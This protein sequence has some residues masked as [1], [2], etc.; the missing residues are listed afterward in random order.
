[1][2]SDFLAT[3]VLSSSLLLACGGSVPPPAAPLAPAPPPPPVASA[4]P[5]PVDT[6][7]PSAEPTP[8][9]K[10]KAEALKKLQEDRTKWQE[11]N[12]AEL[13]RWTPEMHAAAKAL[14]DKTYPNMRAA[15]QA[16]MAS[17]HRKPGN[18]DRDKYRHP[19][20]TLTFFGVKPMMSVLEVGPGDGWYTELIAPAV[21][22]KGKLV[23]TVNDPNGPEDQRGTFFGQRFKALLDK[24]PELFGNVQTVVVDGKAP[25]L[26]MDGTIDLVLVM[27]EIHGMVDGGT[28]DAWLGEIR[29]ALKPNGVL[30]IEEHRAKGD[31]DPAESA[32][33]GYVPEKWL[34]DHVEAAGFKLAGKSEVN[35]NPKDT[36][37]YPEGVWTLPPTLRLGD[38]DREKYQAIGESDRM[39]LK[40]VKGPDKSAAPKTPDKPAASKTPD[41][42]GASK[43][44]KSAAS[45]AP[46]A[47]NKK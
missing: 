38:K 44:D 30:G 32:K 47:K 26:D 16:A 29:K 24:A 21:A 42:S 41:K 17:P 14:A 20:E 40:F 10:K 27:R 13:A 5:P 34:I 18:A 11:E 25:R 37:D 22:A 33:R 31:A 8:E 4:E 1:M 36:K 28:L 15:I 35:A 2:R 23:D 7:P 19:L 9:E 6:A 45:K 43:A 46:A 12:K 39:T 3:L